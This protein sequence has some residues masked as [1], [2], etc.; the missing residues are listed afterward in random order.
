[1]TANNS[2]LCVCGVCVVWSS[3]DA[4]IN[5]HSGFLPGERKWLSGFLESGFVD[6]FRERHPGEGGH[7]TWWSPRS[8]A[9]YSL[10][11][12]HINWGLTDLPPGA[13]ADNRGWRLDYIFADKEFYQSDVI[14]VSPPTTDRQQ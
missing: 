7:Y 11:L 5:E 4:D 8:G 2:N 9:H 1:M 3:Q 12:L 13:R 6:T 10:S 14:D